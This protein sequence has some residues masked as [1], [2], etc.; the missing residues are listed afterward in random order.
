M[1]QASIPYA[2]S[3]LTPRVVAPH[4]R[5]QKI[6]TCHKPLFKALVRILPYRLVYLPTKP[7]RSP[8]KCIGLRLCYEVLLR[9]IIKEKKEKKKSA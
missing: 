9:V 1:S 5:G 8:P 6:E 3:L 4:V 7:Y 2:S